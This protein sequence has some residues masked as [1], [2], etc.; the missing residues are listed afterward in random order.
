MRGARPRRAPWPRGLAGGPPCGRAGLTRW[1]WAAGGCRCR[2]MRA[3]AP[4][5]RPAWRWTRWAGCDGAARRPPRACAAAHARHRLPQVI[6]IYGRGSE[7]D[8]RQEAIKVQPVPPRP[9]GQR[10]TAVQVRRCRTP[11][12]VQAGWYSAGQ[13]LLRGW[14]QQ[15]PPAAHVLSCLGALL[16]RLAQLAATSRACCRRCLASSWDQVRSGAA[17]AAAGIS[18]RGAPHLCCCCMVMAR[19]ARLRGG[20]DARAAAPGAQQQ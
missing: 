9:A 18:G 11:G 13:A 3:P 14:Q 20:A 8:P 17:A 7:F 6:P 16:H 10:P 12:H 15:Q 4:S 2:A 1:D 5:A 19:R